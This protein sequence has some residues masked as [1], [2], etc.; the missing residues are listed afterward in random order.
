MND[1]NQLLDWIRCRNNEAMVDINDM[2][3]EI[4]RRNTEAMIDIDGPL[5]ELDFIA[6][7]ILSDTNELV[8]DIRRCNIDNL[9]SFYVKAKLGEDV[10]LYHLLPAG[11]YRRLCI[12]TGQLERAIQAAIHDGGAG[13]DPNVFEFN[14][15]ERRRALRIAQYILHME[16]TDNK[17]NTNNTNNT[18]GDVG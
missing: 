18:G 5:E 17:G 12:E 11:E 4:R 15:A 10:E 6:S 14:E 8:E 13:Q 1:I 2:L 3:E 9:L 7:R 16:N